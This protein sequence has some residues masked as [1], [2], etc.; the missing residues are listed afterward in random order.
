MHYGHLK[1]CEGQSP[2]F[3]ALPLD[4]ILYNYIKSHVI[5]NTLWLICTYFSEADF[6]Q[7]KNAIEPY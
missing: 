4:L 6:G 7:L 3:E 2:P 5:T 1:P